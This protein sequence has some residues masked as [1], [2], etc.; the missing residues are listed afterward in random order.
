MAG[1]DHDIQIGER[2]LVALSA[3]ASR[4][5]ETRPMGGS[6]SRGEGL[7]T[8][9]PFTAFVAALAFASTN[10]GRQLPSLAGGRQPHEADFEKSVGQRAVHLSHARG[11]AT[12]RSGGNSSRTPGIQRIRQGLREPV[13]NFHSFTR[14]RDIPAARANE[15]AAPVAETYSE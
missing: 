9:S 8:P 12:S 7:S 6:H 1:G 15:Q 5:H 2:G 10:G 13:F 4:V 11:A 3:V 14:D